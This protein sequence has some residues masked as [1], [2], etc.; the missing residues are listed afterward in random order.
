MKKPI[1]SFVL[2]MVFILMQG[3]LPEAES[4]SILVRFLAGSEDLEAEAV[5]GPGAIGVA[6]SE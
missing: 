3:S 6:F 1:Y 2:R 5:E 4:E